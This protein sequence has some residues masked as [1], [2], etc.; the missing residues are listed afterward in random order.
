MNGFINYHKGERPVSGW[1][2]R[3]PGP[4]S[5]KHAG[6]YGDMIFGLPACIAAGGGTYHVRADQYPAIG[7]L[8]EAQPYLKIKIVQTMDEWRALPVTHD[9][10][11]FRGV[12]ALHV[13]HMHLK[14]FNLDF[15]YS[16]PYL[17]NIPPNRQGRI[18]I[19][20]TGWQSGITLT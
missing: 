17:F 9:L 12:S 13:T 14:A 5:F 20:D 10:D 7:R 3:E 19:Q 15:D 18:V 6:S 2:N 8:L 1:E 4:N 11:M 16:K